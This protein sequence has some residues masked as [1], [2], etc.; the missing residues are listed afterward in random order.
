[1]ELRQLLYAVRIAEEQSF[2]K[3]AEKLHLAQPSLSQQIAKLER[4]LGIILFERS[5]NT[6]KLTYAGER[7][8]ESAVKILDQVEQLKKEMEDVAEL[9]RGT[10]TVGSLPITGTHI[11]PL[12]LPIFKKNYPGVEV[13]LI[14]EA[15][16]TLEQLTARGTTEMSL[17]T[18]PVQDP[19]LEWEEIWQEEIFLAVPPDHPLS[20]EKEVAVKELKNEAFIM[21]KKGQGFRTLAAKWCEEAG[22]TPRVVFESSNI[23]TV[24]SLVAAGMG[25][26][27]VPSMMT[28]H[29]K[30]GLSPAYLSL[31]NPRPFRTLVMAYRRG[32][33]RSQAGQ[34]F[35]KTI[36]EVLSQTMEES[37]LNW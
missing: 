33:Y 32:R 14:E 13:K 11:L 34:A 36:K 27:Y 21:L 28:R 18:L 15:T 24:K 7:F 35:L 3:A 37:N 5:T 19:H 1:M 31:R 17:L 2:S 8:F 10:L 6:L 4:E 20:G 26:A 29:Q 12:V 16:R 25:I 22:F 23:E 9:K 30:A